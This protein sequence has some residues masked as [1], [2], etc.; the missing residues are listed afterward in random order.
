MLD[1]FF[2]E[3]KL[4]DDRDYWQQKL[5]DYSLFYPETDFVRAD[6]PLRAEAVERLDV[7][8][9]LLSQLLIISRD[10][11]VP[12]SDIFLTTFQTL[13]FRRT[14]IEDIC[15]ATVINGQLL[16]VRSENI[17]GAISFKAFLN[18]IAAGLK[19]GS[20]H[21]FA[22]PPEYSNMFSHRFLY[23][24]EERVTDINYLNY[25]DHHTEL[26]LVITKNV[27]GF[28]FELRFCQSI[29]KPETVA[30]I[31]GHFVNLIESIAKS[32]DAQIGALPMITT[33]ERNLLADFN[34]TL[35]PYR[36]E[37]TLHAIFEEQ[38]LK[39]PA[40][41]ALEMGDKTIS[42]D[43]LNA[44]ANR[45]A[46]YLVAYGVKPGDN[47]GLMVSR[48]FDMI[49]CMFAI[50]KAG[51][52]Y[53]PVDP[54]YPLD[55]QEYILLNSSVNIV[56]TDAPYPLNSVLPA[57]SFIVMHAD[58]ISGYENSNLD[59]SISSH[60]LAYTIYTSGSTGRPK[61]VMIEHHSAV[62]LVD[63][64]NRTF[65]VNEHDRLLFVT[66]MCFDLSVYDVFGILAVGGRVVIAGQNQVNDIN[67]LQNMLQRYEITFWD[68]VPTTLDYLV[69][70]LESV[71]K[72][73]IQNTLRVVFMSGDWIPV[74]LP[75]R[76]KKFFPAANV[77]SLGGATEATVWSNYFP[78]KK[79]EPNWK[80][81]PYGKPIAN[82]FFYIL[83]DQLQPMP[84]GIPG[85]LYIGG[86]GVAR[87]YANDDVKTATSF[88]PDPFNSEAGGMM[89]RTGDLGRMLPDMNMQFIGRKDN[90]VKINGFRVELGEI[91]S[92][93]NQCDLVESAVVLAKEDNE[94][95]K[96]LLGYIVPKSN[97]DQQGIIDLLKGKL[98][99]YMVPALWMELK[100]LPLNSNG[101]I[102]RKALP[103]IDATM[104][105]AEHYS[106]PL[107][108]DEKMLTEIW[109]QVMKRDQV[110]IHD[111]FFELGGH[112]L[113]AMQIIS[114]LSKKI[115]KKLPLAIF[116]KYPTVASLLASIERDNIS[117]G[118]KCLVP[119][120]ANGSKMPLYIIHGEGLHVLNFS[121]L[122]YFVDEEQ[123]LFGLQAKGLDGID[124]DISSM[125]DIAAQYI[126]EI[127]SHNPNGPY[128]LAGYSFGG[129]V[130][131]EMER[132]LTAMGKEVKM[133]AIFDTN[134]ENAVYNKAWYVKLPTKIKQQIPKFVF[135][136]KS[137]IKEP[138]TTMNY[139]YAYF[140]R[141]INKVSGKLGLVKKPEI[142]DLYVQI[143]EITQKH[144]LAFKA[145][146]MQPFNNFVFLFKAKK[147]LYYV[148][149]FKYL[150]W[151]KYA[152]KG[153]K[154]FE[155][156]GDHITMLQQPNVS[157]FGR[158]LQ[159]ALDNC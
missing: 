109:Q 67:L 108:E 21:P 105:I 134:A 144:A 9:A 92:V 2:F 80:S 26:A 150:G 3:D 11:V 132:Q 125:A 146:N 32:P 19:E 60:Q 35:E 124:K 147:R 41:L 98:P 94:G 30:V 129:F 59:L 87:G 54:D 104:N 96:R 22:L 47:V 1:T 44:A 81:I 48:G 116:F 86:V 78:V 4:D 29:Y 154:V 45:L 75:E 31:A 156:P 28:N 135:I 115:G 157:E 77:V 118:W 145:Y 58:D 46:R 159:G 90:Q 148:N 12:L 93:L 111:N 139:Q 56:I 13:L 20:V 50:I 69:K 27:A 122:S 153:V 6:I 119:I 14:N 18:G 62:N 24:D 70:E 101:K 123:P 63:W 107:S 66:S 76:I 71:N 7:S 127:L 112:S 15:I 121:D 113:M 25:I 136:V 83:N 74:D 34:N 72:D 73:Y 55:R 133:L 64:V 140:T 57:L 52:A 142:D 130:A 61:G 40:N 43:E 158:I 51:G 143:N 103:D 138:V 36:S 49:I 126:S 39:T 68:S 88:M 128:A 117:A 137:A 79:T 151:R 53:V 89:Y 95:K 110:G 141:Q 10:W 5:K 97:Y 23:F 131:V 84:I 99:D 37:T 102:D 152:K 91:E 8:A 114:R 65:D 106:A 16:P 120:K 82:N 85:E 17:S 38:V 42:Y 33:A 149:D 100:N 155:V